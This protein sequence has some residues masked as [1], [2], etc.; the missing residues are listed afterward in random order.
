M[1]VTKLPEGTL[2]TFQLLEFVKS[3]LIV[4]LDGGPLTV[5]PT[6]WV[7]TRNDVPP[8][9]KKPTV[10]T[11]WLKKN[12]NAIPLL[13]PGAKH[14]FSVPVLSDAVDPRGAR[15]CVPEDAPVNPPVRLKIPP[16][17]APPL[18]ILEGGERLLEQ[19]RGEAA[20]RQAPDA[21]R[22][23]AVLGPC[24]RCVALNPG[25]PAPHHTLQGFEERQ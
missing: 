23:V 24:L 1:I 15:T 2:L 14:V 8:L 4:G 20:G 25:N 18:Q 5:I 9:I 17:T 22:H 3:R 19:W 10:M 13:Q 11:G 7:P 16:G 21:F 12:S 6:F